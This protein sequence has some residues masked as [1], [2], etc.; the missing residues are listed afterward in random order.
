MLSCHVG[1]FWMNAHER[2]TAVNA[3]PV[4][5]NVISVAPNSQGDIYISAE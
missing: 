5:A 2:L 3:D 4:S 1:D